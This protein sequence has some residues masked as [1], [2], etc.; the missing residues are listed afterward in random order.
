MIGVLKGT[1]SG[2]ESLLICSCLLF[3]SG[4]LVTLLAFRNFALQ[5]VATVSTIYFAIYLCACSILAISGT[6]KHVNLFIYLIWFFP[7]LVFNKLV[8]A[9]AVGRWLAKSLLLAPLLILCCFA[10]RLIDVFSLDLLFLL[11]AFGLSYIAFGLAFDIVTRYREEYLVERE[12]AESLAELGKT[13]AE[14]RLA[15]DKAEAANRAKSEFLANMSHE[16]RTPM[17]GVIGMTELVLDTQLTPEQ[18]DFLTIVQTS[19]ESLLTVINDVL[20]FSKIEAGKMDFNPIGFNLRESLEETMMAMAMRAHEKDLELVFDMKPAVPEFVIG[21][22]MRLRQVLV[23]LVGNAIKFTAHGE[24]VLEV[25]A[26][27]AL[28]AT[29]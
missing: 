22:A 27:G 10:S 17:N 26:R 18:R 20:D 28:A 24:V 4:V 23:N 11:V 1:V 21:D 29:R 16:I 3:T 6:G 19:A 5:T 9:P 13:N 25:S 2:M 15:K 14:L 7:L 12:R 8:N